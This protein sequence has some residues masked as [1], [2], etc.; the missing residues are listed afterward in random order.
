MGMLDYVVH[1]TSARHA[2]LKAEIMRGQIPRWMVK[3]GRT[4]G[5][6][7]QVILSTP[8][9]VDRAALK[10]IQHNSRCLGELSGEPQHI[11]HIVPL[12]HPLVCGLT[13]PWNLEI[14]TARINQAE[15]NH[16]NN[17][18]QLELF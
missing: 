16:W 3:R 2:E 5:Y 6:I 1:R 8:P 7:K 11:C 17:G 10:R 15:S 9:W 14:K 12:R 18:R 13:V 4:A